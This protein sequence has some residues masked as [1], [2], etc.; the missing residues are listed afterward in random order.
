MRP[1]V[2]LLAAALCL[3]G[4]TTGPVN[5]SF[6]ISMSDAR[7]DLKRMRDDVRP[8]QRPIVVIGGYADP[9]VVSLAVTRRLR[10]CFKDDLRII[11][12]QPAAILSMDGARD[13]LIDK[14]QSELPS[15]DPNATTEVDVVAVSMG[16][17]IAR[18]AALPR[19]GQRR[20]R[21]VNLYTLAS[22][23]RGAQTAVVPS[24]EPR[25]TDMRAGSEF[26]TRLDSAPR[27]Y[28][29]VPYGRLGDFIVGVQ[30]TAP[31]GETTRWVPTP[32]FQAAHI[33]VYSDERILADIVRRMRGETPFS[34]DPAAPLP[35]N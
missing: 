29:L 17:L 26:L 25:V 33:Q 31:P 27:D 9:G 28:T 23:H 12:F 21:I 1:V 11:S 10:C 32:A 8:A 7:A 18:H 19:D 14:V 24:F 6:N 16:G 22:P 5:P 2:P 13:R 20:L 35:T 4:C 34:T 3:S 30:N 15:T